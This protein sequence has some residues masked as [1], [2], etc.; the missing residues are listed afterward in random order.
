VIKK[1]AEK[2]LIDK[3][4]RTEIERMWE[5]KSD[6]I[7]IGATSII[8]NTFRKYLK[9]ISAKRGVKELWKTVLLGTACII[10]NVLI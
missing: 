2:I 5:N 9:I 7:K 6:T 8:S 4:L 3:D 10:H 1:A